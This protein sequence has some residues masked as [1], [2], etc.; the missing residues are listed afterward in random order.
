MLVASTRANHN[1]LTQE[2]CMT[3]PTISEVHAQV[4]SYVEYLL[5]SGI[6]KMS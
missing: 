2:V 5:T 1:T 4:N 6:K 3:D